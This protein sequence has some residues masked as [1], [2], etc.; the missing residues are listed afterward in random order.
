MMMAAAFAC[1]VCGAAE[2]KILWVSAP[3]KPGEHVMLQGGDWT[4]DAYVEVEANGRT[5]RVKPASVTDDGLVFAYPKELD[6]MDAARGRLRIG[7]L[8]SAM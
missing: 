6:L 2:P 1:S 5:F 4:R 3:V 8:M 7:L